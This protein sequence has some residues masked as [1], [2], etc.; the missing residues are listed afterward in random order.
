MHTQ[1][2]EAHAIRDLVT[3]M[4]RRL[5]KQISNPEQM[6]VSEQS[7]LA[8]LMDTPGMLPSDS[9]GRFC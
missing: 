6:S 5:K 7:V 2:D 9:C 8:L 4:Q 1:E 3:R